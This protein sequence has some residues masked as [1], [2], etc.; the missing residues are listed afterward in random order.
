MI[1][2]GLNYMCNG[3]QFPDADRWKSCCRCSCINSFYWGDAHDRSRRPVVKAP[4][5]HR[6]YLSYVWP[7]GCAWSYSRRGV[8][9]ELVLEMVLLD[10]STHWLRS[11]PRSD[12][13]TPKVRHQE[14]HETLEQISRYRPGEYGSPDRLFFMLFAGSAI[15]WHYLQLAKWQ[16]Y[17]LVLFLLLLAGRLHRHSDLLRKRQLDS[18]Q[19]VATAH[20]SDKQLFHLLPLDGHLYVSSSSVGWGTTNLDRHM[21]YLPYLFEAVRE[22]LPQQA[23]LLSCAYLFSGSLSTLVSGAAITKYGIYAP[24]MWAGS[25][26]FIAGSCTFLILGQNSS[27]GE[28]IGS[29]VLSGVGFGAATQIPFLA[30]QVV[31]SKADIASGSKLLSRGHWLLTHGIVQLH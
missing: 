29:Q 15:R 13:T 7:F 1:Y 2:R 22:M 9:S 16:D 14:V 6:K 12:A 20:S 5:L 24:F 25:L 31:L 4:S 21:Y 17:W 19:T 28:L 18:N 10:Q 27:V 11:L 3:S 23:G 26:V 8:D 30:V